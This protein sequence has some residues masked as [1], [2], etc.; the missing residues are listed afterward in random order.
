MADFSTW[1]RATL[2]QFAREATDKLVAMAQAE[3]VA[4][5]FVDED[6]NY[7]VDRCD[8]PLNS[9]IPVYTAPKHTTTKEDK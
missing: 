6:G 8:N 2:E 1:D 5:L 7:Q 9:L 3:P 4:Y